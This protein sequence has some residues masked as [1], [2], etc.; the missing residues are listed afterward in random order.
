M[1]RDQPVGSEEQACLSLSAGLLSCKRRVTSE[2]RGAHQ[3]LLLQTKGVVDPQHS[4]R[5]A[6]DEEQQQQRQHHRA[7]RSRKRMRISINIGGRKIKKGE[8]SCRQPSPPLCAS[9]PPSSARSPTTRASSTAGSG[10]RL[11]DHRESLSA[12]VLS[13]RAR[14]G[15]RIYSAYCG[16]E[17]A[18]RRRRPT[19]LVESRSAFS[20]ASSRKRGRLNLLWRAPRGPRPARRLR[21]RRTHTEI[22]PAPLFNTH[23]HHHHHHHLPLP[24]RLLELDLHSH[25]ISFSSTA[26]APAAASSLTAASRH[27]ACAAAIIHALEIS[28]KLVFKARRISTSRARDQPQAC[29]QGAPHQHVRVARGQAEHLSSLPEISPSSSSRQAQ[30]EQ[31]PAHHPLPISGAGATSALNIILRS[32][33]KL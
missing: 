24:L 18:R 15:M 27:S 28:R 30:Q 4:V 3:Q 8:W 26:F 31:S 23:A 11:E 33:C 21:S 5:D 25:L 12:D 9:A 14:L 29:L 22:Y 10:D 2:L 17:R 20:H 32:S 6:M 1:I 7:S 16:G 19:Y 13:N